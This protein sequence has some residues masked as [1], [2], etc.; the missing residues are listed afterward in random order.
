MCRGDAGIHP[1]SQRVSMSTEGFTTEIAKAR[2]GGTPSLAVPGFKG[3]LRGAWRVR[4]IVDSG[5]AAIR[6]LR[7]FE[8][9]APPSVLCWRRDAFL[10]QMNA[11]AGWMAVLA[12]RARAASWDRAKRPS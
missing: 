5:R 2:G 7:V 6:A 10:T 9:R 8:R 12:A 11:D 1:G 4:R 3:N